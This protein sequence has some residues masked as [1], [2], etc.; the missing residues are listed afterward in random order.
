M[1]A[2]EHYISILKNLEGF[3][4]TAYWDV[5]HYSIGHGTPAVNKYDTITKAKADTELRKYV[6][7]AE[8][9]VNRNITVDLTQ[10]QFDALVSIVYNKGCTGFRKSE[11]FRYV[12]ENNFAAATAWFT[13]KEQCCFVQGKYHSGVAYRRNVEKDL[14]E[15]NNITQYWYM[16][17]MVNKARQ[18]QYAILGITTAV[19]LG[20]IAKQKGYIKIDKYRQ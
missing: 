14:F 19:L 12:N 15:Q 6:A 16:L 1:Q 3:R 17:A 2:S 9:C 11:L 4:A 10:G 18:Y 5:N 13:N 7:E 20:T 8:Q